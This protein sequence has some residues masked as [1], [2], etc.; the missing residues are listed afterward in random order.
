M[1]A[2]GQV[3]ASRHLRQGRG[4]ARRLASNLLSGYWFIPATTVLVAAALGLWLLEVDE[5]LRAEG[6]APGFTG[7]PESARELLSTI[8]QSTLTLT[9]LVFSVT[10]VVLQLVSSQFSPRVL[11]TFLRDPR[12]QLTLGVFLA[13]FVYALLVLREVRSGNGAEPRQVPGISVAVSFGFVIA[14]VG[15]F[16]EY[17]HNIA[18]SIR[19]IEI[20]NRISDGTIEA[21]NRVHPEHES[22]HNEAS[23]AKETV[24]RTIPAATSGVVVSVN[25]E[26]LSRTAQKADSVLQV[27][28]SPGEFV[29]EGMPIVA[30]HG[31]GEVD[32]RR[33]RG[34]V[35]LHKERDLDEDP[36]FGFRQLIDI[37]ERALSPAVNDPTT[38]TQCL[39]HLHRL[40]RYMVTRPLLARIGY[41]TDGAVRAVAPQLG[42]DDYVRLAL[43]EI[44]QWGSDSIQVHQRIGTLLGDLMSVAPPERTPVLKEQQR[45]H[46]SAVADS[47]PSGALK[48]RRTI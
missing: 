45:F 40:L 17:I 9:A 25:L 44:R 43:D 18:N 28:L 8:A 36:A 15:F 21:V 7:G 29:A 42:W 20:I 47:D 39:D 5:R 27:L 13:T 34:A 16:V 19:V 38:A 33:V 3:S 6:S 2:S 4:K 11:R 35:V 14:S 10:I 24:S 31:T 1:S 12:T 22:H 37:A 23:P 41:G 46:E 48:N 30:I 26:R 32:D